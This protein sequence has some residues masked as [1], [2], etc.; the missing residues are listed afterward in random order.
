MSITYTHDNGPNAITGGHV[1]INDCE[2]RWDSS[3]N[4]RLYGG[5]N[6]IDDA[7]GVLETAGTIWAGACAIDLAN[8]GLFTPANN[9][10]ARVLSLRITFAQ[11]NQ[12]YG[13]AP[14]ID[15]TGQ[16]EVY[17]S[18]DSLAPDGSPL[19]TGDVD[20]GALVV[21]PGQDFLLNISPGGG[22]TLTVAPFSTATAMVTVVGVNGFS[23]SVTLSQPYNTNTCFSI[24]GP[25]SLPVPLQGS[26]VGSITIRNNCSNSTTAQL[27]Y[28]ATANS[29][30]VNRLWHTA[31]TPT[32]VGGSS[33]DFSV[34]VDAPSLTTL[35]PNGTVRYPVYVQPINGKTGTV[36]LNVLS[37][38]P[39]GVTAQFDPAQLT[40]D[41]TSTASAQIILTST[42]NTPGGSF[43]I[44]VS[45]ALGSVTRTASFSVGAQVT[46]FQVDSV[47]GG[48][49]VANSGQ[50][51]LVTHTVPAAN[52]PAYTTCDSF[53]PGISC[54]VLA[55]SP[56][57]VTI[58]LTANTLVA[59]GTRPIRLNGGAASMELSVED[60]IWT[61]QNL[62][63]EMFSVRAGGSADHEFGGLPQPP[64]GTHPIPCASWWLDSRPEWLNGYDT[65][66]GALYVEARPLATTTPRLYSYTAKACNLWNVRTYS[67]CA[68]AF[69]EVLVTAPPPMLEGGGE[70]GLP[71]SPAL[72][73]SDDLLSVPR[74]PRPP[75]TNTWDAY[76]LIQ[77]ASIL[78]NAQRAASSSIDG[79]VYHYPTRIRVSPPETVN[80]S[81]TIGHTGDMPTV[82]AYRSIKYQVLDQN[83]D[84]WRPEW[85]PL[86][87]TEIVVSTGGTVV[88]A[89]IP[90]GTWTAP[91]TINS[92][93]EFTD[94]LTVGGSSGARSRQGGL[95]KCSMRRGT[96]R[97]NL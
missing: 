11:Q 92:A 2:F 21:S 57:A 81:C 82:A 72:P 54:R 83:G 87:V 71:P 31:T 77:A 95:I 36:N 50:E 74:A 3:R 18:G 25:T 79:I 10:K 37:A 49:I 63:L 75:F 17:A 16:H 84:P 89:G 27:T 1:W 7:L 94:N 59:S 48:A 35:V 47:T 88:N 67:S 22:N 97:R 91:T 76:F 52:A 93:G 44:T 69:G 20:L 12:R 70:S 66:F 51:E 23:G 85:G 8:S 42:A 39:T 96:S 80:D 34:A 78:A 6:G 68:T 46:T 56:G 33:S 15:F 13:S 65:L 64:C 41:G 61:K 32:F 40:L 30:G 73:L 14:M 28:T 43:P 38:L 53:D 58:G 29:Q 19:S 55:T 86:S 4:I 90:G 5:S 45:A 60:D 62:N 26:A 24:Y 9:P